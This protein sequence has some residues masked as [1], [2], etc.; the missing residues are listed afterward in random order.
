MF[1]RLGRRRYAGLD[2][3]LRDIMK[4]KGLRAEDPFDHLVAQATIIDHDDS[5]DLDDLI[6]TASI[7]LAARVP[8]TTEEL[9]HS[10]AMGLEGGG[11]PIAH[12]AALLH[13]RLPMLDE[14]AMVLVRCRNGVAVADRMGEVARQAR[15]QPVHAVFVLVSGENDPGRHLRILA[16]LAGRI[17]DEAFIDD[18]LRSADEQELKETLLRDD[19][20]L[21][22]QLGSGDPVEHWIGRSLQQLDLPE[23]VLVAL[24]RRHGRSIVP[25]WRTTL[26]EGDRITIIGE[27]AQLAQLAS[28]LGG[29]RHPPTIHPPTS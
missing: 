25:Q 12:G 11:S 18:W 20:F 29:E 14:S 19:R 5:F 26:Q 3:E 9:E 28:T 21:S 8:A 1:E 7:H 13:A 10:I 6:H 4:E 15:E 16:Q 2:R 24:I 27:P 17:E 23:G 22:V